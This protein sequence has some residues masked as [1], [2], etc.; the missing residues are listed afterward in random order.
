MMDQIL[1]LVGW[2]DLYYQDNYK[3]EV[4]DDKFMFDNKVIMKIVRIK[5]RLGVYFSGKVLVKEVNFGFKGVFL[6]IW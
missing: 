3:K 1:F 5:F 2:R 6:K 4:L